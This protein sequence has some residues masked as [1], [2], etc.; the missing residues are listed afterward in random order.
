MYTWDREGERKR[1]REREGEGEKEGE[2]EGER[3]FLHTIN[4][5]KIK[6]AYLHAT[7]L[8]KN[9]PSKS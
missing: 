8:I 6:Y 4:S 9:Q 1:E 5:E 3:D 2:R 7:Y